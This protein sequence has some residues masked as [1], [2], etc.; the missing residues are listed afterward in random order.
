[1][2]K[3]AHSA[4]FVIINP[5]LKRDVASGSSRASDRMLHEINAAFAALKRDD[6]AWREE[7]AE[8]TAGDGTALDG[9]TRE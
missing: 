1:M 5:I 9:A 7:Q 4:P 6:R 2:A 3:Y 8:C